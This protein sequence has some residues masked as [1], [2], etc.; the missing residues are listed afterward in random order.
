LVLSVSK[1]KTTSSAVTGE[2]SANRASGRKW[3]M[4]ELP[5]SAISALSATSP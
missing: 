3:K 1:E 4:T 2:P 5:S